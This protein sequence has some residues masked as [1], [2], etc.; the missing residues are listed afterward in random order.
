LLIPRFP[1][2]AA[3]CHPCAQAHARLPG[4]GQSG[5]I[6]TG[7]Q[8][9]LNDYRAACVTILSGSGHAPGMVDVPYGDGNE[10]V[11]HTFK[12]TRTHKCLRVSV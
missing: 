2:L 9:E 7:V 5:L 1:H 10:V 11:K 4:S 12:H 8:F 3:G 6:G